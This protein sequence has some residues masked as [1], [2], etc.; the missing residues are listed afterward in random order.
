L[1]S[2]VKLQI[3]RITA[4]NKPANYTRVPVKCVALTQQR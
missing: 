3:L 1:N 2:H 4:K